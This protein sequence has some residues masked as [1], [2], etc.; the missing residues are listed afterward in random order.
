MLFSHPTPPSR[1][2]PVLQS[3]ASHGKGGEV[4]EMLRAGADVNALGENQSNDCCNHNIGIT[5]LLS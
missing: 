3:A 5:L 1:N 2:L 4:E